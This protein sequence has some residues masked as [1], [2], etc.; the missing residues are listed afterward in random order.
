MSARTTSKRAP[1]TLQTVIEATAPRKVGLYA[2][3]GVTRVMLIQ[4]LQK[5]RNELLGADQEVSSAMWR[6]GIRAA[7]A[8]ADAVLA[9]AKT[10][11]PK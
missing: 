8:Q 4:T 6:M 2:Q 3:A 9:K 10:V 7:I 5:C 11:W 1:Q